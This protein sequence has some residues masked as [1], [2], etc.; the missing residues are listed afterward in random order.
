[1]LGNACIEHASNVYELDNVV[2]R[3][4]LV[5]AILGEKIKDIFCYV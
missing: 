5:I 1:M 4:K 2:R 3:Q